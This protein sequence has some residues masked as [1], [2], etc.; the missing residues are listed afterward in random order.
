MLTS[1]L[2]PLASTNAVNPACTFEKFLSD[3]ASG[4]WIAKFIPAAN[5]STSCTS[6]WTVPADVSNVE[7]LL[8]A[9]GGGSGRG[10]WSGG[11]GAGG[12]VY[13]ASESISQSEI[14]IQVGGG[15]GAGA[16]TSTNGVA[17]CNPG[18]NGGNTFFG[19]LTANGGGGGGPDNQMTN[20]NNPST[21]Q[22]GLSGGSGGGVGEN[23]KN[24]ASTSQPLATQSSP[25]L[26]NAGGAHYFCNYTAG[27]DQAG[28]G[29]GGAGSV[30]SYVNSSNVGCTPGASTSLG[31]APERTTTTYGKPGLGG[32]GTAAY[33][34][35]ITNANVQ[36]VVLGQ[37]S[38]SSYY[39]AG[40]GTGSG[41][42][43]RT[44]CP[45]C[46]A[47]NFAGSL[48]G[49]GKGLDANGTFGGA[50]SGLD[51][52]GGGGGGGGG[53]GGSGFLLIRYVSNL[54]AL[55]APTAP[56]IGTVIASN[57]TTISVPYTA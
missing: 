48:G 3:A 13:S 23:S 27:G 12:V 30:G 32:S 50:T 5:D 1:T 16:G 8:V 55:A 41:R 53:N 44:R 11:G 37:F 51:F 33:S 18:A 43:G 24:A 14:T 20:C 40:G 38:S 57:S 2:T 25:G 49:G 15:G 9:G 39:V 29:G 47:A 52:T 45:G 7:V 28:S 34:I 54:G 42:S 4:T 31:P 10:T 46:T 17:G 19:S 6:T 21:F 26:G 22:S 56:T 35:F 36:G